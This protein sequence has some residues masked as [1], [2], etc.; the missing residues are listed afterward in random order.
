[1]ISSSYRSPPPAGPSFA[2]IKTGIIGVFP[3]GGH[4]VRSEILV[5]FD[6]PIP[7]ANGVKYFAQALGREREDRLWEGWLEFT[8]AGEHSPPFDSGRE[9]TQPNRVDL[10]YWAQ[11]LTVTYLQGAL[12]RAQRQTESIQKDRAAR[13]TS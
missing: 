12:A 3:G 5:K 1:M 7:D 11:G 6:E 13:E 2:R 10:E 4:E 8:P 9:T